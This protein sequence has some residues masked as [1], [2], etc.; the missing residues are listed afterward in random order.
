[1][2]L[3]QRRFVDRLTV[4]L[5]LGQEIPAVWV[6]SLI[7]QPLVENAVIHGLAGHQGPVTVRLSVRLAQDVLTLS[8][9][10][11][12]A[13]EKAVG[14]EGIGLYNVRERLAVQFEGRASLAAGGVDAE[15]CS[16]I[17]M[18]AIHHSPAREP[19]PAAALVDA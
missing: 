9:F 1:L 6:P 13:P 11:T 15:W 2:E 14:E 5:P 12:I 10:N 3:Q 19:R 18:P 8:V 4:V 7:L 16:E 17:T